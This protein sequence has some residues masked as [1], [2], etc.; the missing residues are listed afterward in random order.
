[1]C[2]AFL[3]V[4]L[5]VLMSPIQ[6]SGDKAE[7]LEPGR[8]Y[9]VMFFNAVMPAIRGRVTEEIQDVSGARR[10]APPT[11]SVAAATA[12]MPP[13]RT[14]ISTSRASPDSVPAPANRRSS[15]TTL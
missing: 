4:T 10:A 5:P 1:M 6:V 13:N 2:L 8:K 9:T 7:T 12:A 11:M 15:T 14:S 3:L